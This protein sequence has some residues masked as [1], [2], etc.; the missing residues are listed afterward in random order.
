MS[1][2]APTTRMRLRRKGGAG[3]SEN[4]DPP[5]DPSSGASVSVSKNESKRVPA[6]KKKPAVEVKTEVT[7]TTRQRGKKVM[8][9]GGLDAD[10]GKHEASTSKAN[11]GRKGRKRGGETEV[12]EPHQ[13]TDPVLTPE[14]PMDTQ[15]DPSSDE[16]L[17]SK[18]EPL[19]SEAK[20]GL[21]G[22]GQGKGQGGKGKAN[23]GSI[24]QT[25]GKASSEASRPK[26]AK[27]AKLEPEPLLEEEK[28]DVEQSLPIKR[29]RRTKKTLTGE[30]EEKA[31]M[32]NDVEMKVDSAKN[33][34]QKKKNAKG[35]KATSK[36]GS[37]NLDINDT[38]TEPLPELSKTFTV[39]DGCDTTN[40]GKCVGAHCSIAGG[41]WHAVGDAVSIGAKSFALFLRSQRQWQ[42]KP[43]EDDNA[44]R[45]QEA[46]IKHGYPPHLILPHGSYLL[47]CGSP[48]PATLSKSR[49][50][51]V[52]ELS[53]C[54]KLGLTL[55][56]FHPGSTCGDITI[57]ECLD[58]IGESIN[59]ALA[60]TS[61]VTAV[62]ENMSRQG[63]TI[64]GDFE[65]LRGIIDRVKDKSRIGVCLDTC[66]AFAAGY[67]LST[68]SGYKKMMAEFERVIGFQY[69]KGVHLND[70]KGAVGCHLDRHE[71]IGKGKIGLEGFRRLMND[72]RF[73]NIPLILET[74]IEF[75]YAKEIKTLNSLVE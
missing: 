5:A 51:L 67:D 19:P 11:G 68:E 18:V 58:K 39:T 41:L 43:L 38:K 31:L 64:G 66:H 62:I 65:E 32:S 36:S 13:N 20:R 53:R 35:K 61:G 59:M 54:Q 47:N 4:Q 23:E 42:A 49:D 15:S 37:T 75:G 50:S 14:E 2:S 34:G 7:M 1:S 16:V 28:K 56:N 72:P 44:A 26:V 6:K 40:L 33:H 48:N 57:E 63:H 8:E 52:D 74:P 45:F 22:K 17:R 10:E 21:R 73:D 29:P 70:S 69:L 9:E 55:Y 27:E 30:K 3:S 46:C 24:S 12:E 25:G 60:K 71:N